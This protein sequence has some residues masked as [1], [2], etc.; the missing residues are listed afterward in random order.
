MEKDGT[1]IGASIGTSSVNLQTH[2]PDKIKRNEDMNKAISKLDSLKKC[3]GL[4]GYDQVTHCHGAEKVQSK[5]F[6]DSCD[7]FVKK[8][9][10]IPCKIC[11]PRLHILANKFLATQKMKIALKPKEPNPLQRSNY[12]FR[13]RVKRLLNLKRNLREELRKMKSCLIEIASESLAEKLSQLKLPDQTKRTM[14]LAV[15]LAKAKSAKGM[16]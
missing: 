10:C 8:K 9:I 3:Q 14:L 7:Q 12:N 11:I 6:S 13:R 16:R 5:W 2:F 15:K 4:S 1:I